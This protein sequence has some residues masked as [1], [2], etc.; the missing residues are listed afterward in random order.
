MSPTLLLTLALGGLSACAAT[1]PKAEAEEVL[2]TALVFW[3]EPEARI[4]QGEQQRLANEQLKWLDALAR[5]LF[6]VSAGPMVCEPIEPE[7][8][9]RSQTLPPGLLLLDISDEATVDEVL[10]HNEAVQA[11]LFRVERTRVVGSD[12]LRRV[13]HLDAKRRSEL[14][15]ERRADRSATIATYVVGV[16]KDRSSSPVEEFDP[17][18]VPWSGRTEDGRVVA[19]IWTRD[20]R[21]A[22]DLL[23]PDFALM[24][25]QASRGLADLS[26]RDRESPSTQP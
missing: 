17:V 26:S 8:L 25:W 16:A 5:A 19:V 11:G 9:I 24:R 20:F 10:E 4:D 2:Y 3:P 14:Q 21:E 15:E 1:E 22:R 13:P 6:L 18:L 23:G 12:A 7:P